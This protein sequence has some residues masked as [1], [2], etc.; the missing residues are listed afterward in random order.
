MAPITV[1]PLSFGSIIRGVVEVLLVIL[2]EF[3]G[4]SGDGCGVAGGEGGGAG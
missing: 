3:T 4:F 2:L 1:P